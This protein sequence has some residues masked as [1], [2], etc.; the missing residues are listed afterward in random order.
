MLIAPVLEKDQTHVSV[1]FPKTANWFDPL[2][3][4]MIRGGQTRLIPTNE[5]KNDIPHY[6]RGDAFIPKAEPVQTTDDYSLEN[7]NINYYADSENR[8]S[9]D[10]IYHDDGKTP[11]AYQKGKYEILHLSSDQ[12]DKD[13]LLIS[14]EKEVG[15]DFSSR[16][17]RINNFK[18]FN[19]QNRPA[20]IQVNDK[21][22]E[23]EY[24]AS[25]DQ[26]MIKNIN[27]NKNTTELTIKF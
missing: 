10:M 19:V 16:M 27:L 11:D 25:T 15:D 3:N 6:I 2:K 18:I 23:F 5:H 1:Y 22:Q 21:A 26:L 7:F 12:I 9:E 8:S 13:E 4:K 20:E 17:K 24:D 14:F